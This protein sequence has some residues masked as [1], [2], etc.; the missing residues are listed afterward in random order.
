MKIIEDARVTDVL[1]ENYTIQGTRKFSASTTLHGIKV[2]NLAKSDADDI[3]AKHSNFKQYFAIRPKLRNVFRTTALILHPVTMFPVEILLNNAD[4]NLQSL[5][6]LRWRR[7]H[8]IVHGNSLLSE[9]LDQPFRGIIQPFRGITH[10]FLRIIHNTVY[11]VFT[12]I[13]GDQGLT[14]T[15]LETKSQPPYIKTKSSSH[16]KKIIKVGEDLIYQVRAL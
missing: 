15:K 11:A 5:G 9:N 6:D 8:F 12:D 1:C 3:N 13:C 14:I 16:V 4:Q 10:R 7:N 2:S